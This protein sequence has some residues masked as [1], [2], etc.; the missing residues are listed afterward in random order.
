MRQ[1]RIVAWSHFCEEWLAVLV[2][3]E[4]HVAWT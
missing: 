3:E 2:S 4:C 1:M